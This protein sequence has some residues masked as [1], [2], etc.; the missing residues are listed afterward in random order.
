M[1]DSACVGSAAAIDDPFTLESREPADT[2]ST[3]ERCGGPEHRPIGPVSATSRRDERYE[4][5]P[6]TTNKRREIGAPCRDGAG[7]EPGA[8]THVNLY[9]RL[10]RYESFIVFTTVRSRAREAGTGA[11]VDRAVQLGPAARM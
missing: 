6:E 4:C 1:Q 5:P 11:D 8:G 10:Y 7:A 9:C 3:A 2:R